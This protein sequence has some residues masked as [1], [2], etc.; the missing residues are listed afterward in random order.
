MGKRLFEAV[1]VVLDEIGQLKN[2]CLAG[3]DGL[4]LAS[5]ET[6]S[7]VGMDLE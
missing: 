4:E 7:Q 5:S 2:L 1:I 6:L 3:V